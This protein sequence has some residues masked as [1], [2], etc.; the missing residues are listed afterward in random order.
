MPANP[1]PSAVR[2]AH[3][4]SQKAR[5]LLDEHLRAHRNADPADPAVAKRADELKRAA[6]EASADL[7]IAE[8]AMR[9]S[10]A[11]RRREEIVV[12][13]AGLQSRLRG[14]AQARRDKAAARTTTATAKRRRTP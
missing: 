14:E 7:D 8:R 12:E 11:A 6:T 2:I 5:R 4:A 10:T 9:A 13:Q 3:D 1:M